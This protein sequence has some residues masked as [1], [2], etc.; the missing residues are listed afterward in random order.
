MIIKRNGIEIELT[1][2]ELRKAY[3]EYELICRVEDIMSAITQEDFD[4]YFSD[5]DLENEKIMHN[6]ANNISDILG[7]CDMY[8]DIYWQV[9]AD[10]VEEYIKEHSKQV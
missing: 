9:V 3:N 2:E 1:A 4:D 7:D 6:I 8:W 5:D 10:A